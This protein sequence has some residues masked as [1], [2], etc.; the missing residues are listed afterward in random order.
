MNDSPHYSYKQIAATYD[1]EAKAHDSFIHDAIFGLCY[2][3][4]TETEVVLDVGIGTGLA[5]EN[6]SKAGLRVVGIDN[7]T[8]M[9]AVSREKGFAE[10]LAMC[11]IGREPFPYD[12]SSFDH[13]ICCG[14]LHFFSDLS[15]ILSEVSRVLKDGGIFCFSVAPAEG[16]DESHEE[17]TTY[18]VPIFKHANC[19]IDRLLSDFRMTILKRQRTLVKDAE[20]KEYATAFSIIVCRYTP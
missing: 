14:V 15:P 10:S 19:S 20:R 3:F 6:F 8:E 2:E 9:L 11:D 13:V 12:G 16:R 17:L 5:S 7:S 1:A 18:Q 4:I